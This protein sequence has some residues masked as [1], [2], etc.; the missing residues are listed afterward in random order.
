[1]P[2]VFHDLGAAV[3]LLVALIERCGE[4]C[5][6]ETNHDRLATEL[7][8]SKPTIK[9]WMATLADAGFISKSKSAHGLRIQLNVDR[10]PPPDDG[11]DGEGRDPRQQTVDLLRSLQATLNAAVDG[12]IHRVA[13]PHRVLGGAA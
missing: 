6:C 12:A 10:L 8:S 1:M 5:T 13:A 7:G 3:Q 9:N 11:P 4:G 2:Q